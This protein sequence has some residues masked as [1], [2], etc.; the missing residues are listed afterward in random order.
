MTKNVEKC[1]KISKIAL[2]QKMCFEEFSMLC[3]KI[4]CFCFVKVLR[5]IT[6]SYMPISGTHEYC[7]CYSCGLLRYFVGIQTD[8]TSR[9]LW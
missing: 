7:Q 9:D 1:R 8:S 2:P 3:F 4:L 5:H 6:P